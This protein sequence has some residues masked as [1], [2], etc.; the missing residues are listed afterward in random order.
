MSRW[1]LCTVVKIL[2]GCERMKNM[3]CQVRQTD[4]LSL[5]QLL[6]II[7]LMPLR[8]HSD[9]NSVN[10]S[11][12]MAVSV[13][14]TLLILRFCALFFSSIGFYLTNTNSFYWDSNLQNRTISRHSNKII[15]IITG[16][17]I[18]RKLIKL[19]LKPQCLYLVSE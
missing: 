11:R 14:K 7:T 13:S 3:S 2:M 19:C 12:L 15:L 18:D 17:M 4:F 16:N 1:R 9:E 8:C 10:L 6:F 5:H